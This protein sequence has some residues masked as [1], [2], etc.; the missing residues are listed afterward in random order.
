M[1]EW[2]FRF[3]KQTAE[4]SWETADDSVMAAATLPLDTDSTYKFLG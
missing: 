3:N 2:R 4:E 1:T